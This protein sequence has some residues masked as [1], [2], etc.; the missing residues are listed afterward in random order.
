MEN[1]L[2]DGFTLLYSKNEK[3]LPNLEFKEQTGDL[4]RTLES[5]V[6]QLVEVDPVVPQIIPNNSDIKDTSSKNVTIK[7]DETTIGERIIS[8]DQI[9]IDDDKPDGTPSGNNISNES[10]IILPSMVRVNSS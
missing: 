3:L 9:E 6:D 4:K 2:K 5:T 7:E 1:I 8:D 10:K